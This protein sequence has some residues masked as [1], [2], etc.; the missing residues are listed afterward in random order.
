MRISIQDLITTL[1]QSLPFTLTLL[2]TLWCHLANWHNKPKRTLLQNSILRFLILCLRY[3][4]TLREH[5]SPFK[6]LPSVAW[7]APRFNCRPTVCLSAQQR[8]LVLLLFFLMLSR[9]CVEGDLSVRHPESKRVRMQGC[10][11]AKFESCP[12]TRAIWVKEEI[13][14]QPCSYGR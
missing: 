9:I 7:H 1:L 8:R 3:L 10:Q 14:W 2:V 5:V 12:P 6:P 4:A 11:M 13:I